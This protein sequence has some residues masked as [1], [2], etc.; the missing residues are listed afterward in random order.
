MQGGTAVMPLSRN[1]TGAFCIHPPAFYEEINQGGTAAYSSAPGGM[2]RSIRGFLME[3]ERRRGGNPMKNFKKALKMAGICSMAAVIMAGMA[4]CGGK[5]GNTVSSGAKD[6][7]KIGFTAALTGGAA[8]YGKSEEEGVRLAV[9]EINQ[10]GDFP[11]DLMMDDT[12]AVPA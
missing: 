10:K 1:G 11:I 4:G 2:I 3:Q 12:K 6:A 9:E 7:A 8:A 5:G